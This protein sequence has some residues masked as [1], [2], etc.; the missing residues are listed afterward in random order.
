MR[1]FI[2]KRQDS[3]ILGNKW[4]A[5]V[6]AKQVDEEWIHRYMKDTVG[7]VSSKHGQ[8]RLNPFVVVILETPPPACY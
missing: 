2:E 3:G 5:S 7:L 1:E 6:L 4:C 8:I